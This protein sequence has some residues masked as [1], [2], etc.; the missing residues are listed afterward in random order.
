MKKSPAI[1]RAFQFAG[2][3]RAASTERSAYAGLVAGAGAFSATVRDASPPG[4]LLS[5]TA[6]PFSGFVLSLDWSCLFP[7]RAG[8]PCSVVL[9][10]AGVLVPVVVLSM[11]GRFSSSDFAGAVVPA[12][13]LFASFAL[14]LVVLL[15][16]AV[17]AGVAVLFSLFSDMMLEFLSI[18]RKAGPFSAP[19]NLPPPST[20]QLRVQGA[21][22]TAGPPPPW[23]IARS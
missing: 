6:F 21:C 4:R 12:E 22:S 19:G 1:G 9:D 8:V 16:G 3:S 17:V 23:P 13:G 10:P 14:V 15:C 7:S 20:F 11:R 2:E 18:L 5:F